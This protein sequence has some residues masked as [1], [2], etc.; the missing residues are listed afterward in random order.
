MLPAFFLGLGLMELL[1][2][3]FCLGAPVLVGVGFLIYWLT[4][5][6]RSED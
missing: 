4:G 6:G 2:L 5:S 3:V 1:I